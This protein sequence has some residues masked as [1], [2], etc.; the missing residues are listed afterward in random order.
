MRNLEG[1]PGQP[2]LF[3][4]QYIE[5][6]ADRAAIKA[7]V[8]GVKKEKKKKEQDGSSKKR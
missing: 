8:E 3:D 6:I 1:G 7:L 5:E 2:N 4:K